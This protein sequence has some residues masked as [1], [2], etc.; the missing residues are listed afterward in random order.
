MT[1]AMRVEMPR[2]EGMDEILERVRT[3]LGVE[4][5]ARQTGTGQGPS[6]QMAAPEGPYDRALEGLILLLHDAEQL[7]RLLSPEQIHILTPEQCDELRS[8]LTKVQQELW[9]YEAS[10]ERAI[11]LD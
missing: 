7:R 10:L 5:T 8:I 11:Q 6:V 9:R 3:R 1:G 2:Y 4:D